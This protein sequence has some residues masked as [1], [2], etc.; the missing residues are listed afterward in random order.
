M[1]ASDLVPRIAVEAVAALL[2]WAEPELARAGLAVHPRPI[3][4]VYR[5]AEDLFERRP[6][7]LSRV[8]ALAVCNAELKIVA[9]R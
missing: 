6:P 9:E 1:R 7:F 3:F 8:W 2:Q 5:V 4:A